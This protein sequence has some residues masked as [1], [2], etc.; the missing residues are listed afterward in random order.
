MSI[1]KWDNTVKG[2][3]GFTS[4][5]QSAVWEGE[6]LNAMPP[7]VK[8]DAGLIDA[9]VHGLERGVETA[10]ADL[11][12]SISDYEDGEL[13]QYFAITGEVLTAQEFEEVKKL[14][15]DQIA[16]GEALLGSAA[17][18]KNSLVSNSGKMDAFTSSDG[19]RN[20]AA[21]QDSKHVQMTTQGPRL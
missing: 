17:S 12:D 8:G 13:S 2:T 18:A 4:A 5:Q 11:A 21:V 6:R 3:E 16:L 19:Y 10:R 15:G 1:D 14:A 9:Y 20:I 7:Q